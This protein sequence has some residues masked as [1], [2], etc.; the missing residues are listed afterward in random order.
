MNEGAI[1]EEQDEPCCAT[2]DDITQII[3]AGQRTGSVGLNGT[4]EEV[5]GRCAGR[6]D[7]EIT[8]AL[9]TKSRLTPIILRK[10]EN[11]GVEQEMDET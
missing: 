10:E 9:M 3:I 7:A 5:A 8:D 1:N 2:V 11:M 4:P 6:A